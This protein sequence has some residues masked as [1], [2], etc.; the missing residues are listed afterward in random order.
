VEEEWKPF[1]ISFKRKPKM[2]FLSLLFRLGFKPSKNNKLPALE[3]L[4]VSKYS[5]RRN[6][7]AFAIGCSLAES[8]AGDGYRAWLQHEST[9]N[10]NTNSISTTSASAEPQQQQRGAMHVIYINT[11][12]EAKA[13]SSS[14]VPTITCTSSNVLQTL[15]HASVQVPNNKPATNRSKRKLSFPS[16]LK[17]S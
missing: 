14:I 5:N 8:A 9:N 10:T 15:L 6:N 7:A 17:L 13:I 1:C 4:G 11:S 16:V 3:K 12:L 2:A